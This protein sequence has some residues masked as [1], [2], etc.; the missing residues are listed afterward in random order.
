MIRSLFRLGSRNSTPGRGVARR[1]RTSDHPV[2]AA[3]DR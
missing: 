3:Q 2:R 1:G